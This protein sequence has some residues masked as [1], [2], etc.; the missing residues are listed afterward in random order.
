MASNYLSRIS[1]IGEQ[2]E[3]DKKFI[4]P[5]KAVIRSAIRS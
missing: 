3:L 4:D 1:G 2:R 5:A